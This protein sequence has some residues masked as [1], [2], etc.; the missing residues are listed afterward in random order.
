MHALDADTLRW[1]ARKY[2]GIRQ[3]ES[4]SVTK[5]KPIYR[6]QTLCTS[7]LLPMH[8]PDAGA[9]RCQARECVGI[10]QAES[11]TAN[12]TKGHCARTFGTSALLPMD[13][14]DPDP[15][16]VVR[17]LCAA[18]AV[19]FAF[20]FAFAAL[21]RFRTGVLLRLALPP[22]LLSLPTPGP[23]AMETTTAPVVAV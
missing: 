6:A 5:T 7:A 9:L 20:A 2:V 22:L 4:T 8:A 11:T 14:P 16:R 3:P 12:A 19:P 10:R 21:P 17:Y 13:A 23:V 1:Q 18:S 15:L